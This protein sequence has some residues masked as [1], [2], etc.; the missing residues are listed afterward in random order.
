MASSL[1]VAW[2]KIFYAYVPALA[3]L[4]GFGLR[5]DQRIVLSAGMATHNLGAA[6]APLL[7]TSAI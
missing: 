1:G 6:L 2:Q 7:P 5:D 4:L 3:H